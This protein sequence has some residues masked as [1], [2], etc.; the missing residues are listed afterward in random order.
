MAHT[1]VRSQASSA[2]SARLRAVSVFQLVTRRSEPFVPF[3]VAPL[4]RFL[5]LSLFVFPFLFSSLLSPPNISPFI[6]VFLRF[7][8]V[9]SSFRFSSCIPFSLTRVDSPTRFY[10][11]LSLP[12]TF[13]CP[14]PLS[15]LLSP[16]LGPHTESY[17]SYT[18][19][20]NSSDGND[21]LANCIDTLPWKPLA[22]PLMYRKYYAVL[23]SMISYSR[24]YT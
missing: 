10:T 21:T 14:P 23:L 2:S 19:V 17:Q 18:N 9:L 1:V 16:L 6:T 15:L 12:P 13:L 5:P 4:S 8:L 3:R 7:R 11:S 24:F 22:F 20:E